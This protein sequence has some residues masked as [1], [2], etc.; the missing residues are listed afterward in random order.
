M[1]V[2]SF[3]QSFSG[4]PPGATF[5][6][7]YADFWQKSE[8]LDPPWRPSW[9]PKSAPGPLATHRR[10][11][12]CSAIPASHS[13]LSLCLPLLASACPIHHRPC[14]SGEPAGW[15][16][17]TKNCTESRKI[18]FFSNHF[19]HRFLEAFFVVFWWILVKFPRPATSPT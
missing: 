16:R 8:I 19:P 3:F 7:F 5:S 4:A 14:C 12:A 11:S 2:Q 9:G 1:I 17:G 13:S 6:R 18:A 10:V 15:Q